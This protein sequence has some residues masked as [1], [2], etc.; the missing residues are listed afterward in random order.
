MAIK[1]Q[2]NEKK[3]KPW[4]TKD[5][6][7]QIYELNLWG[8]KPSEFYSG[9]GSHFPEIINPYIETLSSFLSSFGFP[10]SVCDLGCGDFNV[11]KNLIKFTK[12]YI[13]VDIV[14]PLIAHN[15]EK[16]TGENIEFQCLDIATDNL[17]SADC[18]IIRQ[19]LQHL[20]NAEIQNI[21]EKLYAYKYI[22]LTEHIPNGHF[23]PNKEIISG[24]GTRLK[25]Q[26]GVNLV[27]APFNFRIKEEKQ[28]LSIS[29]GDNQGLIQTKLYT[30]F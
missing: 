11:G 5:V 14:A 28:L 6:M 10:P 4:P 30:T 13:A 22:V 23:I 12:K 1:K 3:G 16:Y 26:S 27:A 8:G 9:T 15:K 2:G 24:Q 21:A 18:A 7:K 25:K 17:P 20:S 19:V 29:L